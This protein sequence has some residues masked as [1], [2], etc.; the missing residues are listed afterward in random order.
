M[1]ISSKVYP[2]FI[3]N[4]EFSIYLGDSNIKLGTV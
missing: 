2:Y 4:L 1:G 3:Y